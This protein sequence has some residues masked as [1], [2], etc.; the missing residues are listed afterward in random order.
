MRQLIP[1]KR[2]VSAL[3]ASLMFVAL[4][5]GHAAAI[6]VTTYHNDNFRTGWNSNE[7][8]LT[9]SSVTTGNF[10]VLATVKTSYYISGQPL[11]VQNLV[12]KGQTKPRDVVYVVTQDNGVAAYDATTGRALMHVYLAPPPPRG[13]YPIPVIVGILS[14]P[15]IDV[16]L[17]SIYVLSSS[18]ESSQPVYRLHRLSLTN[19][20]DVVP[21]VVVAATNVASDGSTPI[22]FSAA[23]EQN[24]PALLETNGNVYAAFG[25]FADLDDTV[26]RG[27]VLGWNA[28]TLAPL[29]GNAPTNRNI[30]TTGVCGRVNESG[31]CYLTSIWMSGF[32]PAADED[33]NIYFLTSNSQSGTYEPPFAIQESAV[34][35]SND[36]TMLQ[37]I[38]TPYQVDKWDTADEDFG[39]GGLTILPEQ[40]GPIP[41][42][43]VAA[44][45]SGTMYLLNRLSMGGHVT[46]APDNVVGQVTIGACWC[47]ESYFT[48]SDG[49]G[50]VVSSGGVNEAIWKVQTS[51]SVALVQESQSPVLESGQDRGFFTAVSSNGT[52][53]QT[54]IVWALARPTTKMGDMTLYA[55]N[56]ADSSVL[57]QSIAGTWPDVK[58]NANVA[59]VVA[60]GKVYIRGGA[61]LVILGLG[62]SKPGLPANTRLI[63]PRPLGHEVYGTVTAIDGAKI[64]L[65]LRTG[66]MLTVDNS[67][68][69]AKHRTQEVFVGEPLVIDGDYD[70]AGVYH[71]SLTLRAKSSPALWYSDK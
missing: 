33:N 57:F 3:L 22:Q 26:T 53:P 41:Y 35:V 8:V 19:L 2:T 42:L 37:G 29:A 23:A 64:S 25:S 12:V 69:V 48:G 44:G 59:P 68:P 65:Q 39:S 30:N 50:R 70:R 24:R 61:Q 54:A 47:G 40:P 10:G 49:I 46:K 17:N 27:W 11:I 63:D 66:A 32:G 31:P 67:G 28:T 51:P 13:S 18:Y 56:A 36:L 21:S 7:T 16:S 6:N 60:N 9:P 1:V 71:A 45:K 38:F 14:T 4:S 62:A 34:K 5:A 55:L 15:V 58:Q 20:T 43:A 52:Q